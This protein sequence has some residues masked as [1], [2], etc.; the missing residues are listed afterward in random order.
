MVFVTKSTR[1]PTMEWMNEQAQRFV[2]HVKSTGQEA[3]L[4]LCDQDSLYRK[5]FDKV[6]RDAGIR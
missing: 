1:K 5:E 2:E 3:T 6:L 4:L